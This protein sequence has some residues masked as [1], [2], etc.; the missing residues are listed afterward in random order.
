MIWP[1]RFDGLMFLVTMFF[2]GSKMYLASFEVDTSQSIKLLQCQLNFPRHP[3][4]NSFRTTFEGFEVT[5]TPEMPR[6]KI[7]SEMH[8]A[9]FRLQD[10][11]GNIDWKKLISQT[12]YYYEDNNFTVQ[13]TI[14]WRAF[15]VSDFLE[16]YSAWLK[17]QEFLN[18]DKVIC[19]FLRK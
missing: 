19:E 10:A 9:Y 5:K 12:F 1:S 3:K 7:V 8:S 2:K 15:P 4:L 6:S 14:S 17:N 13:Y 16:K 18:A 11:H